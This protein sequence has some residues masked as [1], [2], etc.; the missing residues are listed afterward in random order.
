[1][2]RALGRALSC[3]R[4]ARADTIFYNINYGRIGANEEEVYEA[5]RQAQIHDTI[6]RMPQVPIRALQSCMPPSLLSLERLES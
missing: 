4:R 6:L 2:R 3:A 5:A 1:M